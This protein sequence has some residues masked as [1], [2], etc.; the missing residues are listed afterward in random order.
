MKNRG[1]SMA[2]AANAVETPRDESAGADHAEK[3]RRRHRPVPYH[4]PSLPRGIGRSRTAI[5]SAGTQSVVNSPPLLAAGSAARPRLAT[6]HPRPARPFAGGH[7]GPDVL[8]GLR[9]RGRARGLRR[10]QL[11]SLTQ[12]LA[13]TVEFGLAL[14]AQAVRS[15]LRWS[16]DPTLPLAPNLLSRPPG[17]FPGLQQVR[18]LPANALC[19]PP[20]WAIRRTPPSSSN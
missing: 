11:D 6:P 1:H 13:N 7:A 14:K 5:A 18:W 2:S 9:Q 15:T 12:Q 19:A 16:L 10:E 8:A 17:F 3:N 20:A 4:R